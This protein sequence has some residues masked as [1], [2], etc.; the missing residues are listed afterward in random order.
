LINARGIVADYQILKLVAD[1]FY[2]LGIKNFSFSLNYLGNIEIK[3]NYK[4][5]LR[6]FIEAKAIDLCKN[7]QE[8]Y[9][10]NP[11]RI[12]D[13]SICKKKTSFPSYKEA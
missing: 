1:I 6:E 10:S 4:C 11:L 8:R 13:C 3:E 2:N 5:K 9:R 12:L 7:C